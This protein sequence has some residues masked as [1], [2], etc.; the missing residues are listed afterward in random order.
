MGRT[1]D[2]PERALTFTKE[3]LV[4]TRML[5]N[6]VRRYASSVSSL[7]G[8][9]VLC[10][11]TFAQTTISTGSIQGTVTDPSGAVVPGAKI[12]IRNTVAQ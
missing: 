9:L 12:S 10:T 4:T 6:A 8:V 11:L 5:S 1:G 2:P 7:L 3:V